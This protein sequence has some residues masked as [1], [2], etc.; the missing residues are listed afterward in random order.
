M[1]RVPVNYVTCQSSAAHTYGNITAIIQKKLIEMFPEGLFKTIHVNSK[2]AHKQLRSLPNT[3]F[4]KEKP[5]FILRPRIEWDSNNMFMSD[6]LINNRMTDI[7][8]RHG[9]TSLEE[10]FL[11]STKNIC[12]KYKL[13]RC[14]MNFDVVL[15]FSTLMQQINYASY[16]KNAIGEN[17]NMMINTAAESYISPEIMQLISDMSGVPIKDPSGSID[18]FIKYLNQHSRTPI[19]YRLQGSTNSTEFF[20]YY[21]CNIDTTITNLSTDEGEKSGQV[22]SQYTISFSLKAE[23]WGTGLYYLFSSKLKR[24]MVLPPINDTGELIPLYTDVI[25]AEDFDVKDGWQIFAS[26]SCKI[27]NPNDELDITPVL[28][29][30]IRNSI[31]SHIKRGLDWSNFLDIRMR[32]QGKLMTYG[33]DFYFDP[34]T[35]KIHFINC[36]TYYTYKILIYINVEY[37]NNYVEDLLD[38]LR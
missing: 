23:F 24:N 12:L 34:I 16:I 2:I 28:N 20:R 17:R 37:V 11:D 8:S 6:T 26:P 7:Y 14:V 21:P 27:E 25:C 32:Q 5:M 36:G 33:R 9:G 13:D 38:N 29:I 15:I 18:P 19:T 4:K 3:V 31:D 35:K 10:F 30:S 1:E 22:M